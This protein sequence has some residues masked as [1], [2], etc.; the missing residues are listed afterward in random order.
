MEVITMSISVK[1]LQKS[2]KVKAETV[3]LKPKTQSFL[4]C[5]NELKQAAIPATK[6]FSV[7]GRWGKISGE[8]KG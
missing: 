2:I 5:L 1:S 3:K 4:F 6:P 7:S 8:D